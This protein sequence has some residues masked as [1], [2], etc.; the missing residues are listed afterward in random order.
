MGGRQRAADG[1]QGPV[2]RFLRGHRALRDVFSPV[3]DTLTARH[4]LAWL[5][6]AGLSIGTTL[7]LRRTAEELADFTVPELA[8][9]CAVDLLESVLRFEEGDRSTGSGAPLLRAMAVSEVDGLDLAPDPVGQLSVYTPQRLSAQCLT[10]RRPVMLNRMSPADY[11]AVAPGRAAADLMR[12]AGVHSYMAVP[13]I[14]RGMLLGLADFIR[15]GRRPS[16]TR[17]DLALAT[18][19][20]SKAAVYIDNARLYGRERI[21][22][23]TLQRTLLPRATPRTPGLEVS[24]CYTPTPDPAGVGGDWFDVVALPSGRSAVMVG[25]VMGR[26]LAAAATTG[27]LRT[28]A[29]TLMA[30]D[31]APERVLARLD[32]AVRDL[33]E[34]Q[35][36]TCLCAVYDPY[37]S[38]FRIASAGHLPPL[39][40]SPDGTVSFLEPP[41]GAPLGTGVIPYDPIECV[42]PP[43]SRLLLYTD[44]LIRSR[45]ADVEDQLAALLRTART[46]EPQAAA[47]CD[48]VRGQEGGDPSDDAVVVVAGT[49]AL[50]P[51]S[52]AYVCT[53]PPDGSAASQARRTVRGLLV[54]WG[55]QDL[56]DST[57][58]VV[59]EL[60]GN[61]LRYGNA[62]G[63]LRLVRH[64]RLSVEVSDTGPDLPQIQH[65]DLS[66]EGG[67]GLQLINMLCRRWGACRTPAG[68]VVWAEQD[69]PS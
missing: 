45:T 6:A 23:V 8:D 54:K 50:T 32:L 60:V 33:E 48:A 3:A 40:T 51:D 16:F 47:V 20:V 5:N 19:L 65:A 39:L 38:T 62:P 56:V 55:L 44:G 64:E 21:Q 49:V 31:I 22:V 63:E 57:E 67:R 42:V 37:G 2:H 61:A 1:A 34:D 27:R 28:V 46:A 30:L 17:G 12:R 41:V 25:D 11:A 29:R 24:S 36:A 66:D 35:V 4:R 13:L 59:S 43:G 52:D 18:E 69:L 58:L 10:S 15:A 26:G 9:G 68:K 53:L 7:D 14:A